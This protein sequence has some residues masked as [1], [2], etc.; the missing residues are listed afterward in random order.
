MKDTKN[1]ELKLRIVRFISPNPK[2]VREKIY[3]ERKI[4]NK[5]HE[6]ISNNLKFLLYFSFSSILTLI[7]SDI[8][9]KMKSKKTEIVIIGINSDL[10][11]IL[12]KSNPI[13]VGT[14]INK[15]DK[16]RKS[17]IVNF[18]IKSSLK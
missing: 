4:V 5:N 18:F 16:I 11:P 13:N 8:F 12:I 9:R 15:P 2:I 10:N 7:I 17:K 14:D 6:K 3:I 1:A